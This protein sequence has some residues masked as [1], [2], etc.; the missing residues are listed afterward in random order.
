[1]AAFVFKYV[2]EWAYFLFIK[3]MLSTKD[4]ILPVPENNLHDSFKF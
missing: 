1:M 2:F 3:I 4:P